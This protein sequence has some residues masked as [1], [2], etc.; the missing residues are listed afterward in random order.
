MG[1]DPRPSVQRALTR[2]RRQRGHWVVIVAIAGELLLLALIGG[3][4][5]IA[6]VAL[7]RTTAS[8]VLE[9]SVQA[10][11]RVLASR[12]FPPRTSTAQAILTTILSENLHELPAGAT[13]LHT[14]AVV[15]RGPQGQTS[16]R[17]RLQFN[18]TLPLLV[19]SSLPVSVTSL[20]WI[21]A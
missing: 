20:A 1:P 8:A 6:R 5:D 10:T 17:A 7:A 9:T 21:T 2:W 14:T 12:P 19:A 11:A 18:L 3:Y 15:I 13:D 16:L 4:T